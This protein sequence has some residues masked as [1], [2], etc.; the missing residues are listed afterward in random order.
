MAIIIRLEDAFGS[1]IEKRRRELQM[2]QE[3]LAFAAGLHR[4]TISLL[5]RGV[6]SPTLST[7]CHL[8]LALGLAPSRL[9]ARAEAK[10]EKRSRR[11]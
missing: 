8:A 7:L 2:S 6:K 1:V 4:T 10:F 11:G 5:E 9:V 3:D